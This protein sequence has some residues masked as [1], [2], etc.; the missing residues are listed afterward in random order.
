VFEVGELACLANL[1]GQ[2]G[3]GELALGERSLYRQLDFPMTL[4]ESIDKT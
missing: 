4:S 1:I 2:T 3:I